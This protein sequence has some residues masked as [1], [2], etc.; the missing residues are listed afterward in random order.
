MDIKIPTIDDD[1]VIKAN[2]LGMARALAGQE[3][4]A[5]TVP[6]HVKRKRRQVGKRQRA[7]RKLHRS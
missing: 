2:K 3:V 5:G 4:Y 6:A 1:P 7:A